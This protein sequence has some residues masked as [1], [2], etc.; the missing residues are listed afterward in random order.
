MTTRIPVDRNRALRMAGALVG[1]ASLAVALGGCMHTD[2]VATT[3]SIPDDY[4]LR[5]PIAGQEANQSV[6]IFVGHGR[7]GLTAEQRADVMGLAQSWRH[8]ATGAITAD[9][10]VDTS[11]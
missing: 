9:V 1:L 2:E 11:N 8:E 5:H 4:R 6:V 3:A 7:G 10:P